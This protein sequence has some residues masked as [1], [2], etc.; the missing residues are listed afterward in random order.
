MNPEIF[1][2]LRKARILNWTYFANLEQFIRANV[3][4]FENLYNDR[5]WRAKM[6]PQDIE[7][8]RHP[9]RSFDWIPGYLRDQRR[10]LQMKLLD[11]VVGP[12]NYDKSSWSRAEA[13]YSCGVLQE[14]RNNFMTDMTNCLES[15]STESPPSAFFT[16]MSSPEYEKIRSECF[17]QTS[18]KYEPKVS[19]SIAETRWQAGSVPF[20]ANLNYGF[21]PY[22][23]DDLLEQS[24]EL[25]RRFK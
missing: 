10:E 7:M 4:D 8:R 6:T 3:D 20:S 5:Y 15:K 25:I 16:A 18:A 23:W 12:E 2:N 1:Q 21:C 17:E 22:C 13:C 11:Y 14:D 9:N 24:Q 19:R